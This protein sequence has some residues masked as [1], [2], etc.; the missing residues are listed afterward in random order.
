METDKAQARLRQR[1]AAP[2]QWSPIGIEHR[3][4]DPGEAGRI[5]GAPDHVSHIEQLAIIQQRPAV[6]YSRLLG[7]RTTP[8][9]LRSFPFTRISGAAPTSMRGRT[10]RPT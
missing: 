8:R 10:L 2:V 1:D 3:Q 6:T 9:A 5:S 4:V 7:T